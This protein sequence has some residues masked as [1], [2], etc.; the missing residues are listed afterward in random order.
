MAN[1]SR[2]QFVF[3]LEIYRSIMNAQ[4]TRRQL[5]LIASIL[6]LGL[7]SILMRESVNRGAAPLSLNK[8]L[9]RDIS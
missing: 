1:V 3:C 8:M 9:A 4:L 5:F 2:K 6:F 7:L